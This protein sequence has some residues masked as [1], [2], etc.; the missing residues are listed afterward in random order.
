[1][2]TGPPGK[3]PLYFGHLMRAIVVHHQVDVKVLRNRLVNPFQE[4]Q[5]LLMSL[6]TMETRNHFASGH[7]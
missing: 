6:P 5:E 1:M 4:A 7:I 2:I 3:P